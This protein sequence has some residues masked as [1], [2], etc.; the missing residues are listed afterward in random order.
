[1]PCKGG[2]GIRNVCFYHPERVLL[3]SEC[4]FLL[5]GSCRVAGVIRYL[6]KHNPTTQ[7]VVWGILP[8]GDPEAPELQAWPSIFTP[9]IHLINNDLR[10]YAHTHNQHVHFVDCGDK[11][12]TPAGVSFL[13]MHS[14]A[15]LPGE[16][17]QANAAA[18]MT[19]L[20]KAD[21]MFLLLCSKLSNCGL[22][23]EVVVAACSWTVTRCQVACTPVAQK[24]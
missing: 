3:F 1:M 23:T 2:R 9:A 22:T 19:M 8:R 11:F 5:T 10:A 16:K 24:E 15:S 14:A 20:S 12:I 4:T 17:R 13:L 6:R 18:H 7:L 21:V